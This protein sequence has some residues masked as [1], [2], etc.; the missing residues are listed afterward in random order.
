MMAGPNLVPSLGAVQGAA[1]AL[2]PLLTPDR[3]EPGPGL[4]TAPAPAA[5]T[6]PLHQLLHSSNKRRRRPLRSRGTL[7]DRIS[8]YEGSSNADTADS[9]ERHESKAAASLATSILSFVNNLWEGY[10]PFEQDAYR[11]S[12]IAASTLGIDKK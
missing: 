5:W 2:P 3:G 7:R 1:P 4:H 9:L 6:R 10:Y 8:S 11:S 12:P